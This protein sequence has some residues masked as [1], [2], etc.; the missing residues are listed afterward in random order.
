MK[1]SIYPR[2]MTDEQISACLAVFGTDDERAEW[3]EH[4]WKKAHWDE[5]I[6]QRT[7]EIF[8]PEK[9]AEIQAEMSAKIKAAFADINF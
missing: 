1:K 5:Y 7:A 9:M 3:R 8:P 4:L 2:H 6:A